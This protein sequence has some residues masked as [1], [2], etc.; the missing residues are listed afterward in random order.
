MGA[1]LIILGI[2][3][4]FLAIAGLAA[5]AYRTPDGAEQVVTN[6]IAP[7]LDDYATISPQDPFVATNMEHTAHPFNMSVYGN[8]IPPN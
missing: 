8:S 7:R 1:E 5:L 4:F 2:P 3:V 6:P